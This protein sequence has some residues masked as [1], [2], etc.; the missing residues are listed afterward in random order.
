MWCVGPDFGLMWMG[1]FMV[2]EALGSER[3]RYVV[4]WTRFWINVDV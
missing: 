4:S 2:G 1:D 3:V